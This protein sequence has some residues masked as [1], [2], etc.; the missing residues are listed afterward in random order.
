M[1]TNRKLIAK[2]VREFVKNKFNGRCAYCGCKPKRLQVDHI[3]PVDK[4]HFAKSD[5]MK[6]NYFPEFLQHLGENDVNHKDNLFPACQSCNLFK[7]VWT[8]EQFRVELLQQPDRAMKNINHKMS[9]R[10]GLVEQV[11]ETVEFYFEQFDEYK[12]VK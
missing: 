5:Y 6:K 4:F 1:S 12:E 7:R 2:S 3:V 10:F 9:V 8:L 11:K